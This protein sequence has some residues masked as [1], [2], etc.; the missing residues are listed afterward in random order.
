MWLAPCFFL[1]NPL[2]YSLYSFLLFDDFINFLGIKSIMMVLLTLIFIP[3]ASLAPLSLSHLSHLI[4]HLW[5]L[6]DISDLVSSNIF[7]P[8]RPHSGT[9][10]HRCPVLTAHTARKDPKSPQVR[11]AL[12]HRLGSSAVSCANITPL[13]YRPIV[14][15]GAKGHSKD[16]STSLFQDFLWLLIISKIKIHLLGVADVWSFPLSPSRRAV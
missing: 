12:S 14:R 7:L 15:T 9:Q 11:N 1:F 10:R 3:P 2:L 5:C 4:F 13:T 16:H 8:S 6:T